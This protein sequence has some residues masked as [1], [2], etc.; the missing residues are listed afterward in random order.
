MRTAIPDG[1]CRSFMGPHVADPT[2][3]SACKE[4][5]AASLAVE[6]A[7]CYLDRPCAG[8]T[9]DQN[10]L[11]PGREEPIHVPGAQSD[12][13]DAH[14]HI[15]EGRRNDAIE[16]QPAGYQIERPA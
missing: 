6:A 13:G 9:P 11:R 1:A 5:E 14:H 7:D 16:D 3:T 8:R 4:V 15:E 2:P 12:V 10:A